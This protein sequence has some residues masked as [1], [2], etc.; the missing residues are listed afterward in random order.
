MKFIVLFFIVLWSNNSYSEGSFKIFIS[1]SGNDYNEGLTNSYPIKTLSRA[2]DVLELYNSGLPVEIHINQGTYYHQSVFWTYTNGHSI[3]FTP[4]NFT[5]ERPVFDGGGNINTW[6][7][8]SKSNRS[9]S[10]LKF[11]Y[12]KVQNYHTAMSFEGKRNYVSNWNSENELYGMFFYRI[13]G[14]YTNFGNSTAAVRFVNSRS[15]SIA[16]THFVDILNNSAG[17]SAIHAIYFAHYS[18]HNEVLRNRFLR[19]NGDPIKVR[20]ESN[21]NY[22]ADNRFYSSG[23]IAFYQGWYCNADTRGWNLDGSNPGGCTKSTGE[24]PSI[25]NVFRSNYLYGGYGGAIKVFDIR[26]DDNYCG[27]LSSPRLRT[28][29]NVKYY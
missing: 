27:P 23:R 5:N 12:I 14:K 3:T 24:C 18:S 9:S 28:S 13:G 1:P 7:T 11:R 22:M 25:G 15:N 10:K 16:N 4:V 17:A 19:I 26:E 8:L 20:D 2:Q 21:Y 29:N 6:F